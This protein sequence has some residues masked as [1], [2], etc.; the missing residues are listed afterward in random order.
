MK[1]S[2]FKNH[3]SQ[4][5]NL[6]FKLPNGQFIASHFHITELGIISKHF[7]DCGGTIR[8]EKFISFQIWVSYDT[9]HRLSSQKLLNII[10]ASEKIIGNEDLEISVEYQTDTL[11]KYGL[12]F[13][14]HTFVLT[15]QYTDC[16]A[17]DHCGIPALT[18]SELVSSG[19]RENTCCSP[20][21]A[22]C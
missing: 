17:K 20:G 9:D 3:L 10:S 12:D 2:A 16:L 18:E 1:L 5:S 11:G 13:Q 22:C 7:V 21:S 19:V 14:N 4:N 15:K 8:T 6:N